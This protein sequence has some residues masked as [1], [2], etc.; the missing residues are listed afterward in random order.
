VSFDKAKE[1]Q[2]GEGQEVQ[3]LGSWARHSE[4]AAGVDKWR[5]GQKFAH[6]DF[7][8]WSEDHIP[9]VFVE[10]K[11]R[12][13]KWGTYWEDVI[14]PLTKHKFAQR[15]GHFNIALIGVTRYGCGSL[16]EANLQD[17]PTEVVLIERRDRPGIKVKHVR[18][19]GEQLRVYTP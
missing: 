4:Y 2:F 12:R 6:Y 9:F 13:S 15:L 18:Y 19:E 14:F 10:V 7:V 16:V 11:Q 8:G 3:I 5:K 1:V 17:K